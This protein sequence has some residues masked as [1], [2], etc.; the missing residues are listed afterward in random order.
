MPWISTCNKRT[1]FTSPRFRLWFVKRKPPETSSKTVREKLRSHEL[2]QRLLSPSICKNLGAWWELPQGP[3]GPVAILLHVYR[4]S[5]SIEMTQ[6]CSK[7]VSARIWVPVGNSR[8]SA[9]PMTMLMY[10]SYTRWFH[11]HPDTVNWS[12]DVG[13]ISSARI[14]VPDG[15]SGKGPRGQWPYCYKATVQDGT[16]KPVMAWID[17]AIVELQRLQILG[18]PTENTTEG[19]T[20]YQPCRCPS[21]G[22]L[23]NGWQILPQYCIFLP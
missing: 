23:I 14:W 22:R 17:T 11:R 8:K 3:N 21:M 13:V 4:P 16:V 10:I 7:L 15:N 20:G 2:I 12:S 5:G 19:A 6:I 9:G 1:N 18:C